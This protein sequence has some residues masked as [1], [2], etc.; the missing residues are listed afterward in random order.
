MI[1]K[2]V[3]IGPIS[4]AVNMTQ[5]AIGKARKE[6]G[7]TEMMGGI[8]YSQQDIVIDPDIAPD[9]KAD[10]LLHEVLHGIVSNCGLKDKPLG[11]ED[12]LGAL[13]FALLD[14]LRRNPELVS[15]LVGEVQ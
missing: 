6:C 9:Q 14:V 11:E 8:K 12:C 7:E 13:S 5:E 1:P 15:Y 2:H 4:Y 3:Q 10:T